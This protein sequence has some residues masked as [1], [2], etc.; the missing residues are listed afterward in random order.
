[1]LCESKAI[2]LESSLRVLS[3]KNQSS[4][5]LTILQVD[6]VTYHE[7]KYR[8][9]NSLTTLLLNISTL[10]PSLQ[11]SLCSNFSVRINRELVLLLADSIT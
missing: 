10:N 1:M 4:R 7:L 9:R 8:S 3:D 5:F 6:T 2:D 11:M